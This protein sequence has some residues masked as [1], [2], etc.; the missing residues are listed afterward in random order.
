MSKYFMDFEFLEGDIPVKIFGLNIPKWLIKPNNTI[1]PI[2]IGLVSSDDREYYAISKDFNLYEAWNRLE[3]KYDNP[4]P[5]I[6]NRQM[7]YCGYLAE[8]A[9]FRAIPK[10]VYWIREN[11]L[12]PIYTDLLIKDYSKKL[13]ISEGTSEYRR[14]EE[15]FYD[16]KTYTFTLNNFKRLLFKYGKSNKQIADEIKMFI[17]TKETVENYEEVK[18]LLNPQ[19]YGYYSAYDHVALCWLFGKMIDL[20]KGFP[21]YTIDLKQMLDE[22]VENYSDHFSN[23][24]ESFETKLIWIKNKDNYPKQTNEHNAL[25][26]AKFNFNLYKFLKS[27]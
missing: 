16:S 24:N 15:M 18:H 12:K 8:E 20:P 1:Q 26:N 22:K 23:G 13:F 4:L 25:N 3:M 21:M 14:L 10:K 7:G 27:L 6:K 19:F 17:G 9:I 5:P 11:V 2:S